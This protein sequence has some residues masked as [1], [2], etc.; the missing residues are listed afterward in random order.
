MW[1]CRFMIDRST[2]IDSSQINLSGPFTLKPQLRAPN[3]QTIEAAPRYVFGLA[4]LP[5]SLNS[6]AR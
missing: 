3:G 5:S 6:V 4:G 1:V 2:V